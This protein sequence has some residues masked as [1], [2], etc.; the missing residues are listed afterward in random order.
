MDS[1][2]QISRKSG[3][4]TDEMKN[5]FKHIFNGEQDSLWI[6][7]TSGTPAPLCKNGFQILEKNDD[8]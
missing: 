8:E 4:K 2:S 3:L 5:I 6:D 7:L 1:L